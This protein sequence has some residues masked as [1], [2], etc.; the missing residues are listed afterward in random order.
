MSEQSECISVRKIDLDD[1][2]ESLIQKQISFSLKPDPVDSRLE[3]VNVAKEDAKAV[4]HI[5]GTG[6]FWLTR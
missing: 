3:M 4:R 2:I 5:L 1:V 6:Y